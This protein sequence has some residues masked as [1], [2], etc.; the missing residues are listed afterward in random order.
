M[1]E[2]TLGEV[3]RGFERLE[4]TLDAHGLK[5]D[6]IQTQTTRT[7][8]RVTAHDTEIRAI[9]G[10]VDRAIW[11]GVGLNVSIIAGVIVWWATH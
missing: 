11:A 4:K 7:N 9:K 6:A 2:I 8:G 10:I 5:L 1:D 3:A